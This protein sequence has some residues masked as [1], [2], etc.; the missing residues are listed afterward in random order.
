MIKHVAVGADQLL[1][2]QR[3]IT[4]SSGLNALMRVTKHIPDQLGEQNSDKQL[5][6]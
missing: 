5:D 1:V 2:K 4:R 6:C 3:S